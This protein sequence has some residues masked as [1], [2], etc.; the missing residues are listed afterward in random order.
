MKGLLCH[1]PFQYQHVQ[2]F[3][4]SGF[5]FRTCN[6]SKLQS[7]VMCFS[8]VWI[9]NLPSSWSVY[10]RFKNVSSSPGFSMHWTEYHMQLWA[11]AGTWPTHSHAFQ[12]Q[13]SR[14]HV[15]SLITTRSIFWTKNAR[16]WGVCSS[17]SS[18]DLRKLVIARYHSKL[19][20]RCPG[21]TFPKEK[22]R[23]VPLASVVWTKVSR[24]CCT[25]REAS[26][27]PSW[28]YTFS[29]SRLSKKTVDDTARRWTE[30][31]FSFG[32][33]PSKLASNKPWSPPYCLTLWIVL[34]ALSAHKSRR[35]HQ[36]SVLVL[37]LSEEK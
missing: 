3:S 1:I 23:A 16:I 8:C 35:A 21:S 37:W 28:P 7:W 12:P 22:L 32:F 36:H 19:P 34:F 4:Y 25:V 10:C 5:E 29:F 17:K 14:Q 13:A 6:P 18:F 9:V 15:S 33:Q 11:P 24:S 30:Q 31:A 26:P 2:G 27:R 20:S